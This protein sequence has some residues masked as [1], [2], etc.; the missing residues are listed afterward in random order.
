MLEVGGN[1]GC[2]QANAALL[3]IIPIRVWTRVGYHI[4]TCW[5]SVLETGVRPC[6][7]L[8][9]MPHIPSCEW[10][11]FPFWNS[12]EQYHRNHCAVADTRAMVKRPILHMPTDYWSH[13]MCA[14]RFKVVVVVY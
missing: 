13:Q 6:S 2:V 3:D 9:W 8:T 1:C 14:V 12:L 10:T 7:S 5:Q 4:G 11:N